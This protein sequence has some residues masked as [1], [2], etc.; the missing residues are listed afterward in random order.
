MFLK[1]GSRISL[2]K[3]LLSLKMWKEERNANDLSLM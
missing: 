1:K 3:K 2:Q